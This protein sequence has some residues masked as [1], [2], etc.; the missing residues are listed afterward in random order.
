M[1][2]IKLKLQYKKGNN[3]S[4]LSYNQLC[5]LVEEN[6]IGPVDPKDINAASIDVHLGNK[7][8]IERYNDH[9]TNV[10]DIKKRQLF[11]HT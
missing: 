1:I 11:D 10:I 6:V 4:L 8:I 3:M 9:R 7:I 5:Q 2:G